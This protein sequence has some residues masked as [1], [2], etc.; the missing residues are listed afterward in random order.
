MSP[1]DTPNT[2][3]V[4]EQALRQAAEPEPLLRPSELLDTA[5]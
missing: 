1:P 5:I 4:Q 2:N 3:Q